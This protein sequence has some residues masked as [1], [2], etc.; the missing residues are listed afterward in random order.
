MFTIVIDPGHGGTDR[1][2]IGKNGYVEADG[3][4]AISLYMRKLFNSYKDVHV[5]LTR[6]T[7]KTL[8]L[9]DRGLLAANKDLFISEHTNAFYDPL[10]NGSEVFHSVDILND[11]GLAYNIADTIAREFSIPCRGAKT[12]ESTANVGEDYYTV[13]DVAQDNGCK[14]VLLVE[15]MFHTNKDGEAI[16]LN[17]EYLR[18]IA[19]LQ[20]NVIAEHFGLKKNTAIPDWGRSAWEKS[21]VKGINDGKGFDNYA[22]EGQVMVYLDR[23]GLLD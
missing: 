19:E 7:D 6:D 10:V 18:K 16:L 8:S 14:H 12:K 21:V 3:V 5:T 17:Q 15:S 9:T 1:A 22:T 11:S 13:I 4:L 23:L 2:N 20:V